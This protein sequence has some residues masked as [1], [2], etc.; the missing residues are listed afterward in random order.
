MQRKACHRRDS[1]PKKLWQLC[2][3]CRP[4]LEDVFLNEVCQIVKKPARMTLQPTKVERKKPPQ[5]RRRS[6]EP[7]RVSLGKKEDDP[8]GRGEQL[9]QLQQQ[10]LQLQQQLLQLHQ[11]QPPAPLRS[12]TRHLADVSSEKGSNP[13]KEG[14]I[15]FLNHL[16]R[17]HHPNIIDIVP[18]CLLL[19]CSI[20]W[21]LPPP[22][23]LQPVSIVH[24]DFAQRPPP[25]PRSHYPHHGL[26]R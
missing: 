21:I 14:T 4:I 12:Q 17:H 8:R 7:Q 10:M 22:W 23:T 16:L 3:D 13:G 9:Q 5:K 6:Q 25:P 19:L 24:G 11:Q 1:K 2:C 26:G 18:A 20:P 15:I